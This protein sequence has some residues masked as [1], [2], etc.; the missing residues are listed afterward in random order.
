MLGIYRP[1]MNRDLIDVSVVLSD[2]VS[3][4]RPNLK[5]HRTQVDVPRAGSVPPVM[6]SAEEGPRPATVF[7]DYDGGWL[8][9]RPG[10]H[11]GVGA[12]REYTIQ[13]TM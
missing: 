12:K 10:R 8:E 4:I 7:I 6:A 5:N 1:Q 3:L 2:A 13:R 9:G 11:H